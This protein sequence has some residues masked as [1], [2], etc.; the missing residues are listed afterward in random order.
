MVVI[1]DDFPDKL[2]SST[3]Y[4]VEKMG[5]AKLCANDVPEEGVVVRV[6]DELEPFALKCKAFAFLEVETKQLDSGE[7]DLETVQSESE[8]EVVV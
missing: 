2:M 6:D 8:E 5:R 1:G 7:V 4:Y 3:R